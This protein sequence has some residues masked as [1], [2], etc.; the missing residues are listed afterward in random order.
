MRRASSPS[1]RP[2]S[3]CPI[4]VRRRTWDREHAPGPVRAGPNS[5]RPERTRVPA[6][7]SGTAPGGP[8]RRGAMRPQR[9]PGQS[10]TN[11]VSRDVPWWNDFKS[12]TRRT[13]APLLTRRR[14]GRRARRGHPSAASDGA[15]T[16]PPAETFLTEP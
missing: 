9:P 16:T 15:T 10:Q 1:R 2:T 8:G 14:A 13:K 3:Y 12:G 5:A 7:E 4:N 11:M 6:T